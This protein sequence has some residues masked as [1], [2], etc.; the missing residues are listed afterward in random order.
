MKNFRRI[1]FVTFLLFASSFL[2]INLNGCSENSPLSSII[3]QEPGG[4][5]A[6]PS[7]FQG[8]EQSNIGFISILKME[9]SALNVFQTSLAETLKTVEEFIQA[10][11]GGVVKIGLD[12]LGFCMLRFRAGDLPFDATVSIN[13]NLTEEGKF[14]LEFGPEGVHFNQPVEF[15]MLYKSARLANVNEEKI[16]LFYYNENT[17][18]WEIQTG[19]PD[20][21]NKM[22]RGT[23]NHFSRYALAHSE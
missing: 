6:T 2:I 3:L 17:K 19:K 11:S 12:S 9:E 5:S 1:I 14:I 16:N 21:R 13:W 23:I 8:Y 22:F 4:G 15:M 10:D 18:I 7:D 20:R